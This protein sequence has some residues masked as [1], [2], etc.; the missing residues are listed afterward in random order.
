MAG[1]FGDEINS[2]AEFFAVVAQAADLVKRILKRMPA[3]VQL[4]SIRTQLD[5]IEHWTNGGRTPTVEERG[6]IGIGIRMYR[7]FS[8]TDDND[9]Q[10]L[11]RLAGVIN[12]YF[13]H[14]PN[15]AEASDPDNGKYMPMEHG[16]PP[17]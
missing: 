4:Q 13:F 17:R 11:R 9:I 16:P 1:I 15:D 5:A 3:S 7:E 10:V 8:G 6:K 12:N 14:W 2:R